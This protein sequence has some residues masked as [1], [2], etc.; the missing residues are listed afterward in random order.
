MS[1]ETV[2]NC[3]Q[4][5]GFGQEAVNIITNDNE[6][7]EE[8]ESLVTQLREDHEFT[9]EDFVTFDDN[10]TESAGQINT[11]FIDWWQQAREEAIK[12]VVPDTSSASQAVNTVS[13]DDEDDQKENTPQ[14]LTTSE[15]LQHL[16]DLLHF[17]ILEND[18]TL[19]GPIAEVTKKV[20]NINLSALKQI[21]IE[22]FCLK[23]WI[24]KDK[25]LNVYIIFILFLPKILL[26]LFE[27]DFAI[28]NT[29]VRVFEAK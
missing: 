8:F 21:N 9:V 6:I 19:I 25:I 10:L 1:T 5:C 29:P 4:K 20:Q 15:A 13:D 3:F 22:W 23:F 24:T 17:S 27:V 11:D 14:H 28:P 7:Y 18:A 26:A 16:D 2:I 12:E